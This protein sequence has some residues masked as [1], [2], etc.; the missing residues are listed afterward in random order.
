MGLRDFECNEDSDVYEQDEAN[1]IPR[2]NAVANGNYWQNILSYYSNGTI[3]MNEAERIFS[4][5][6]I[7][8]MKNLFRYVVNIPI[9]QKKSHLPKYRLVFGTNSEDGLLLVAD[10][11]S[12]TWKG[13][14]ERERKGQQPLF[15]E[16]DFPDVTSIGIAKPDEVIW[17]ILSTPHELKTLLV[18][19]IEKYGICYSEAELK[20]YCKRMEKDGLIIVKREP[21][22]TPTGR[23]A[24]SWEY[25]I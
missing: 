7:K 14:V 11:M 15:E 6:Y 16:F 17:D 10:K 12:R 3:S 2:M 22:M 21:S 23:V 18:K 19:L 4:E 9:K 8:E 24:A 13:F 20:A 5:T 1:S 25:E